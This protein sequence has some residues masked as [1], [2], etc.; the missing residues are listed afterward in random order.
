MMKPL[1][2]LF[3]VPVVFAWRVAF[4]GTLTLLA[5]HATPEPARGPA[6]QVIEPASAWV[7]A[8]VATARDSIGGIACRRAA[9]EP[10]LSTAPSIREAPLPVAPPAS[11]AVERAP[12]ALVEP[13]PCDTTAPSDAL[14]S[15]LASIRAELRALEPHAQ[16]GKR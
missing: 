13:A 9:P 5:W 14:S 3:V 11:P 12:A 10:R 2:R 1:L 15:E 8:K 7:A 6:R 4:Y 16:R